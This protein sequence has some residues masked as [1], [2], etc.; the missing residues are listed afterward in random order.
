MFGEIR[1]KEKNDIS[2]IIMRNIREEL[3]EIPLEF[4][5]S[6]SYDMTTYPSMTLEIPKFMKRRGETVE[7]QAYSQ[8]R[9]KM[10]AILDINGKKSKFII[11]YDIQEV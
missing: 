11:D 1:L 3:T 8:V 2:L 5:K 9:G 4:I 7:I 10:V 6:I